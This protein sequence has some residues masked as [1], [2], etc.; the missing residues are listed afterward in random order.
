MQQPQAQYKN[1]SYDRYQYVLGA[2]ALGL[3]YMLVGLKLDPGKFVPVGTLVG[4]QAVM[5][6]YVL[7]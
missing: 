2:Q 5:E 6:C 3:L 1:G 7:I 4:Y